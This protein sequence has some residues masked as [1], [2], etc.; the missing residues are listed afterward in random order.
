MTSAWAATSWPN[1][2]TW[3][4]DPEARPSLIL[5]PVREDAKSRDG[6]RLALKHFPRP[7]A[8]PILLIHGLAQNDR[9]WDSTVKRYSFARFLH[10]QGFD[11]W[12]GNLRGSGTPGFRSEM[13]EGP[14][15]WTIDDYSVNDIPGLVDAVVEATGQRPF[16]VGHSLAAWAIEGY[17][18]GLSYDSRGHAVPSGPLSFNQQSGIRGV[19]TIAGVYNLDWEKHVGDA[20]KHPITSEADF[21]HS[22]YELELLA[23]IKP[24]Y[25]V[26]PRLPRLPL[27]W[28]GDVLN[29]PLGKIPFIGRKL[30][31]LY[32]GVQ[33]DAIG[34]PILSMFYYAPDSDREMVRQHAV[35]GLEDLGPR[36]V[37]QLA[38]AIT[39]SRTSTYYH[40]KRGAGVYDYAAIRDH[41][42]V[43]TLMIGGGRDRLASSF[44]IFKDGFERTR[45]ADKQFIHVEDFGH[46]DIVTGIHAPREVMTPVANWLKAHQ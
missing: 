3:D 11:V 22:N 45:S 9:G 36:V 4:L 44:Q 28:I 14:R 6:L 8:Q 37:E 41:I 10:A 15:H 21:Y 27:G 31:K 29:L 32:Q 16:V 40:V 34:T 42:N 18:A 30:E 23:R 13:P 20:L 43:P 26:V 33:G 2:D 19:I 46:L 24:L 25:W 7:G 39:D 38:N 5:K 1:P 12:A 35:D 17:L